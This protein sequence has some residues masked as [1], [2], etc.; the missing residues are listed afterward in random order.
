MGRE[1]ERPPGQ[2]GT[3]TRAAQF[4]YAIGGDDAANVHD[5]VEETGVAP[6]VCYDRAAAMK[7]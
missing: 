6:S 7:G 4:V 3:A 2:A 1:T 5:S